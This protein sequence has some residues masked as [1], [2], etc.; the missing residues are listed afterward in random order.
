MHLDVSVTD[1]EHAVV[2]AALGAAQAT[3]QPHPALWRVLLD[4]A[5]HPFCLTTATGD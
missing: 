1:L 2:A 3:H 5:G 4:P